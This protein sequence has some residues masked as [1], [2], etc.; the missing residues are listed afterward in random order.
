MDEEEALPPK[1]GIFGGIGSP[2]KE[3]LPLIRKAGFDIVAIWAESQEEADRAGHEYGVAFSSSNMDDVLLHKD[4]G[5]LIILSAP[6][7]HSQIAVK[8]LGIGKHVYVSA[9]C[10]INTSQV[11]RMVQSAAYYPNLLAS[12]GYSLRALP[13]A[14]QMKKLIREGYI[15]KYVIHCDVRIDSPNLIDSQYSWKCCQMMGGGVLNQFGSHIIDLLKYL[16]DRKANRIHGVVRTVQRNTSKVR[17]I[18]QI[19]ADDVVSLNYETEDNCLVTI[20]L[21]AQSSNFNQELTL[22]GEGGQLIMRNDNLF[23]RKFLDNCPEETFHV[24]TPKRSNLS[25]N[26]TELPQIYLTSYGEMFERLKMHFIHGASEQPT[27]QRISNLDDASEEE[28]DIPPLS[29][30]VYVSNVIEAARNSSLEKS[31]V[32]IAE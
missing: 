11:L 19:T 12:V 18:R 7:T 8:A 3:L 9:P 1:V 25:S 2:T 31:W 6:V 14:V 17:G 30:A 29:D 22:T 20:T 10:S 27:D 24:G 26:E 13:A 5:L 21:N 32:K 15:G 4:V 16:T 23:G 28:L